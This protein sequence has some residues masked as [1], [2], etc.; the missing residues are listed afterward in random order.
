MLTEAVCAPRSIDN[1]PYAR[2]AK[3]IPS[4]INPMPN[5]I[6]PEGLN[7]L[8]HILENN[9]ANVMIKNEFKIPNH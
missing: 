6:G 1:P 9:G 3:P 8:S 2:M 4:K 5:F 7:L